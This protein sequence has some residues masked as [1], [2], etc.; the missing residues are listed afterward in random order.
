M[1]HMA[2]RH[3]SFSPRVGAP[4]PSLLLQTQLGPGRLWRTL[5][6]PVLSLQLLTEPALQ[7]WTDARPVGPFLYKRKQIGTAAPPRPS[8]R[9]GSLP[10]PYPSTLPFPS[11]QDRTLWPPYSPALRPRAPPSTGLTLGQPA[12]SCHDNTV[13]NVQLFCSWPPLPC[14]L[15]L[16]YHG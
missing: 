1:Q 12:P 13:P 7:H 14:P 4:L 8:L 6:R 3:L 16:S 2:A 15:S 9:V 11:H 5:Y 10:P